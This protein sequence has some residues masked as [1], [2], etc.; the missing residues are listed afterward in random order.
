VLAAR[1]NRGCPQILQWHSDLPLLVI[2][3]AK[4]YFDGYNARV[5]VTCRHGQDVFIQACRYIDLAM[6]IV[7]PTCHQCTYLYILVFE[8]ADVHKACFDRENVIGEGFGLI[9]CIATIG[10]LR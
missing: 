9:N 1:I 4:E 3:E 8:G 6:R 5:G 7:A 2:P 10:L